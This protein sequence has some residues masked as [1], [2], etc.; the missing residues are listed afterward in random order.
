[1]KKGKS[2]SRRRPG[3]GIGYR[4]RRPRE[5]QACSCPLASAARTSG[6]RGAPLR[7]MAPG[8]APHED[9]NQEGMSSPKTWIRRHDREMTNK[10]ESRSR[11][12]RSYFMRAQAQA[13]TASCPQVR[14]QRPVKAGHYIQ[15]DYDTPQSED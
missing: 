5:A 8:S 12:G 14:Q 6:K 2:R 11:K 4:Q 7:R 9:G 10:G 1:M 13:R 15:S 3:D